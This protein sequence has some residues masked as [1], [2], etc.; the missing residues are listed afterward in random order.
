MG[1][2]ARYGAARNSCCILAVFHTGADQMTNSD[3]CILAK[4]S[5]NFVI[6]TGGQTMVEMFYTMLTSVYFEHFN[7]VTLRKAKTLEF[8]PF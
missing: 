1:W 3:R 2:Q 6:H 8:W 4:I 7:P 5:Y